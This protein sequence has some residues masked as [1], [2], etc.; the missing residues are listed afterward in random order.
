MRKGRLVTVLA[1]GVFL[2]GAGPAAASQVLP[3][4][5][6]SFNE[7]SGATARDTSFPPLH[8]TGTLRAGTAWTSGRYSNALSFDGNAAGVNVPNEAALQGADVT[9]SAWVNLNGSPGRDKYILAKGSNNCSAASYG[10]YSG[11]Q[12]GIRFYVGNNSG[13][14]FTASADGG[15]GIWDGKW[16]NVIGTF[17]GSAVH[18]Y[19]DG[20]EVGSGVP[21]SSPIA[22]NVPTTTDLLIGNYDG[23]GGFGFDG[24]IDEVKVFNRA[25]G[26]Q[27]IHLAYFGSQLLPSNFPDDLV[28]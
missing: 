20:K 15:T 27:E 16:H 25:L 12:G 17:D 24:K 6:W 14:G 18:L 19:I 4:G 7:G 13:L 1:T 3:A 22:Y 28:L 26:P 11:E 10:L 8:D 2:V 21:V 9:V 23:C 5:I